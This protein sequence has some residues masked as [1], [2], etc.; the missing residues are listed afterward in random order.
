M[1]IRVMST[2]VIPALAAEDR[3]RDTSPAVNSMGSIPLN[4]F[5]WIMMVRSKV[6]NEFQ[7]ALFL[8][9]HINSFVTPLANNRLCSTARFLVAFSS[10]RLGE[11][12][13]AVRPL[14]DLGRRDRLHMAVR[15]QIVGVAG[16]VGIRGVAAI[17]PAEPVGLNVPQQE[18]PLAP[19]SGKPLPGIEMVVE[20]N[21][22]LPVGNRKN[23]NG[24][25][26]RRQEIDPILAVAIRRLDIYVSR[27]VSVDRI[28]GR[29]IVDSLLCP[30]ILRADPDPVH[31]LHIRG[32]SENPGMGEIQIGMRGS[33]KTAVVVLAVHRESQA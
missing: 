12:K 2:T 22:S 10:R 11:I 20:N 16:G 18:C 32:K 17:R 3:P 13:T 21:G 14:L 8:F 31:V 26:S 7:G 30:R 1:L 29:I 24:S 27:N 15:I 19:R 28:T 4:P 6:M 23:S 25:G 9:L 5:V 33:R